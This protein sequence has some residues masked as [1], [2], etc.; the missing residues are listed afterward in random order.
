MH[1]LER[2]SPRGKGQ[3]FIGRCIKCGEEGLPM[4]A[5]LHDCPADVVESDAAALLR[6]IDPPEQAPE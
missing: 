3:K 2:T 5:A 4:S 6:L 1:A